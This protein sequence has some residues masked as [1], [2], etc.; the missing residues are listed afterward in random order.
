MPTREQILGRNLFVVFP[1]NPSDPGAT[2]AGN[3]S[4]SLKRVL[5]NRRPDAMPIQ[6]YNI[7]KHGSAEGEFEARYWK[8]LDTPVFN[9]AGDIVSIIHR[10]EDVTEP[11]L[12]Q[13]LP[14]RAKRGSGKLPTRCR[15]WSDRR[16][17]TNTTMTT[18][19]DIMNLPA[20]R[21]ARPS[22]RIGIDPPSRRPAAHA[23]QWRI[24]LVP[25]ARGSHP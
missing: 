9:A 5:A 25:V 8:P 6:K 24:S 3:L 4:A 11:V 16:H 22:A 19:G 1:D 15:K 7:P 13:Q 14:K 10:V 20:C 23:D 2:S 17:R 12:K 21:S 18:I